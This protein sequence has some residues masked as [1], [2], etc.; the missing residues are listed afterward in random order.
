MI[1]EVYQVKVKNTI[2]YIGSGRLGRHKHATSG[3]SHVYMLNYLHFKDPSIVSVHVMAN[4]L[5][6]ERSLTLELE[7]IKH[8]KPVY[9]SRDNREHNNK[10]MPIQYFD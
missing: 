1:Y 3:I 7:M 5:T 4:N 9:N 8:Y 2:C 10:Y 6:K